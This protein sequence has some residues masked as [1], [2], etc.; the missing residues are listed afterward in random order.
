MHHWLEM[1]FQWKCQQDMVT[2][3]YQYSVDWLLSL[4]VAICTYIWPW[5]FTTKQE[6]FVIEKISRAC[7]W[8]WMGI[9]D[10]VLSSETAGIALK[11]WAFSFITF[12]SLAALEFVKMSTSF[13]A[14]QDNFFKM[15]TF[16]F[17]SL[18]KC[19]IKQRLQKW[20]TATMKA[21]VK[22][23]SNKKSFS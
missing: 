11:L 6:F 21:A 16:V 2:V 22:F 17:Q 5:W 10:V 1:N 12:S 15:M 4:K 18:A 7:F 23:S 14:I 19:S 9:F 20:Y 8:N 3:M 13:A